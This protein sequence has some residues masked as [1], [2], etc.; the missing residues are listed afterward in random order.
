MPPGGRRAQCHVA[1]TAFGG[2]TGQLL[3]WRE[4]GQLHRQKKSI[5]SWNQT[6]NESALRRGSQDLSLGI[7]SDFFFSKSPHAPLRPYT[8]AQLRLFN[9]KLLLKL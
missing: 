4:T 8:R 6:T 9:S 2:E 7:A 5:F 1:D 3:F